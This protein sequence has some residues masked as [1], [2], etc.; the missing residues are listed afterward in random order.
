MGKKNDNISRSLFLLQ[1]RY[2]KAKNTPNVV[3]IHMKHIVFARDVEQFLKDHK[4][5]LNV[6]LDKNGNVIQ[7]DE[8]YFTGYRQYSVE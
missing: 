4:D 7:K 8:Y 3:G 2:N 6:K 5:E 1:E